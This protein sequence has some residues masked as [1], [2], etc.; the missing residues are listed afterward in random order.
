[1]IL[2]DKGFIKGDFYLAVWHPLNT[3]L[4]K[5]LLGKIIEI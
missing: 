1:M 3:Y 4:K 5:P 2:P